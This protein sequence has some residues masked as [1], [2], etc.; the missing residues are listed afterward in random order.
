MVIKCQADERNVSDEMRQI[1]KATLTPGKQNMA[2]ALLNFLEEKYDT[3]MWIV[4]VEKKGKIATWTAG[5]HQALVRS[6]VAFA[7]SVD[8]REMSFPGFKKLLDTSLKYFQFP[9]WCLP[10]RCS[11][12]SSVEIE[13]YLNRFLIPL[14][15]N[16]E[17]EMK[18]LAFA[19]DDM[20]WQELIFVFSK[21]LA[22]YT[23]KV[24]IHTN[25]GKN[26]NHWV[27]VIA[28]RPAITFN[29]SSPST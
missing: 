18:I 1:M 17:V 27:F 11:C 9:V 28:T 26:C 7:I 8:P 6:D 16:S 21:D 19:D 22:N 29:P 20:G 12:S 3:K 5:F 4:L 23:G 13:K 15:A 24:W 2:N 25:K 14:R 10:D